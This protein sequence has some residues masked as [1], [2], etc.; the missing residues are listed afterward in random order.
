MKSLKMFTLLSLTPIVFVGL[1]SYL[2]T[3]SFEDFMPRIIFFT[4]GFF[5][6]VA[7]NYVYV[8][9]KLQAKKLNFAKNL[10]ITLLTVFLSVFAFGILTQKINFDDFLLYIP[11]CQGFLGIVILFLE[12]GIVTHYRNKKNINVLAFNEKLVVYF[13]I[14]FCISVLETLFFSLSQFKISIDK[15]ILQYCFT[16]FFIPI[17][18]ATSIS[19]FCL[20]ILSQIKFTRQNFYISI[21][22]TAIVP[23]IILVAIGSKEFRMHIDLFAQFVIGLSSAIFCATII[24]YRNKRQENRKK[25]DFLTNSIS[26]KES[27]YL[28]LKNQVNPHFL[29][30]NLNTLI[31]FIEIDPKKAIEFGHHLSNVYRHYLKNDTED[32]A[33]LSEEIQFIAEYLEVYKAKFEAGFSF[34]I[35]KNKYKNEYILALTLQEII[36]NIFK[37]NILEDENPIKIKIFKEENNL[38]IKN[39]INH[40][41]EVF[42]NNTGLTNINQRNKI[43][44]NREISVAKNDADFE[45]R[46]PIIILEK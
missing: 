16:N 9:E 35:E 5:I 31:S 11:L 45:V 13:L 6:I 38:V 46:I 30:N 1:F 23:F 34:E 36:D 37:H 41:N 27:E 12:Y 7:A 10:T 44:L 2:I 28:Q 18:Q 32:Y 29:F 20:Y 24:L 17:F 22:I 43:L 21:L 33:I 19:M 40:Q 8:F 3:E 39:T 26:K 4:I 15:E 25:I 42:S 14:V